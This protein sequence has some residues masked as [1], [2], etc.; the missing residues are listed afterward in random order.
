MQHAL[1]MQRALELAALGQGA[2]APNPMVG[3]VIV[4]NNQIIG[5]GWHQQYG[6]AHAEVNAIAAVENPALLAEATLYV[7]LEPCAHYGKT[8]PCSLLIIEKG[9]K[10]VVVANVD[11][12]PAVA[13]KGIAM[14]EAAGCDVVIGVLAEQGRWLNRRFFTFQE[15]KRP[16]IILKWAESA[17]GF[18]APAI[19]GPYWISSPESKLLTHRWRAEE[20]GILVGA[21]TVLA[22]NPALT[23]RLVQGP[24]PH[25]FVLEREPFLSSDWQV[26]DAAAPTTRLVYQQNSL[27]EQLPGILQKLQQQSIQSVLVEGGQH[28]L[29]A[30]LETGLWDEIRVFEARHQLQTGLP[31][32]IPQKSYLFHSEIIGND[33]LNIYL[34]QKV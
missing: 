3:C 9:I 23:T 34:N 19:N 5:E 7:T 1:Y 32:P 28:L 10:K 11:P 13:G 4:H 17:D 2:V 14:L 12:F 25:R 15:Q 27:V 31:S 29:N 16:Y 30:F 22:D 6:Q 8:P 33:Q 21:G 24:N 20:S 26:F 18:M